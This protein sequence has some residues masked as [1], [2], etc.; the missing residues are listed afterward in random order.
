MDVYK[1]M[2]LVSPQIGIRWLPVYRNYSQLTDFMIAAAFPLSSFLTMTSIAPILKE[3]SFWFRITASTLLS[4]SKLL[5]S[6]A[7]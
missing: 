5:T 3:E 1:Y 6:S 2:L 4:L 7:R